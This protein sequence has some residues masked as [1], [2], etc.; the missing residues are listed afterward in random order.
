LLIQTN[1]KISVGL[2]VTFYE[3]LLIDLCP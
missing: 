3:I 1:E 2:A